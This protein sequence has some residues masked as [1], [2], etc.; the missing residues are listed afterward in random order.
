MKFKKYKE[1]LTLVEIDGILYVK[2]YQTLV[3]RIEQGN[4]IELGYWS[5]TTKKH[6][7]YVAA[8]MKL[9]IIHYVNSG[10]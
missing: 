9:H 10:K 1:N 5:K 4:L 2:S 6:T 7:N 8:E 3:A